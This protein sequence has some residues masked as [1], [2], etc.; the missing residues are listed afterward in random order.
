[1]LNLGNTNGKG[2]AMKIQTD[3]TSVLGVQENQ[4]STSKTG[5][6]A[7]FQGVLAQEVEK[8]LASSS[9]SSDASATSALS[10]KA[11]GVSSMLAVEETAQLETVSE[12][13]QKV[14]EHIDSLLDKWEN[15][16]QALKAPSEGEDLRQAYGCLEDIQSEVQEL[17]GASPNLGVDNPNL[18]SM[19]DEIEIM[20]VTEQ[21][22]FNRGDYL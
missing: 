15:Y 9:E 4:S 1:L 8:T 12:T 3:Q 19:V 11:L 20:T 10:A 16:A 6:G 14:M 17:K 5:S 18:Q 2:D 13:E 21:I 22:K 7:S